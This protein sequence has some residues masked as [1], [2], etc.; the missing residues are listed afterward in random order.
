MKENPITIGFDDATFNLRDP[1][2]RTT[3][4]IGVVCQGIRMVGVV[5]KNIKID[6]NDST[7]ALIELI[8]RT[9]KHV[10]YV[11]TDTITFGGFNI[12]DI[13]EVYESTGKPIIALT[14]KNVNLDMVRNALLNRFPIEYKNK[15]KK[16]IRAGNLFE[17]EIS[18]AGGIS[19]VYFHPIG[20]E[21]KEVKEL[22]EKL[23]I[24]SKMPEC[25]RMAHLIGKIFDKSKLTLE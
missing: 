14:E 25:V 18:T 3:P 22:L 23:C 11:L 10:Q 16:I 20:I 6:G 12:A 9:E 19:K 4:L 5:K 21:L 13:Q 2:S 15:I 17:T 24:D 8:K 7:E 1:E